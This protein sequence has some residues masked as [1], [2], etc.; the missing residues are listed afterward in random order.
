MCIFYCK[1]FFLVYFGITHLT[2][3]TV[4][5]A[6]VVVVVVVVLFLLFLLW[7][8]DCSSIW[9]L[10]TCYFVARPQSPETLPP[11]FHDLSQNALAAYH[12]SLLYFSKPMSVCQ[13]W[14]RSC[15]LLVI[16]ASLISLSQTSSELLE[17]WDEKCHL[18]S[19]MEGDV[20]HVVVLN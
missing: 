3:D 5:E 17:D 9:L 15:S 20:W 13:T 4:G 7:I 16:F 14:L 10:Y 8:P 18:F 1:Q 6:V 19:G 11:L 12:Y 2:S